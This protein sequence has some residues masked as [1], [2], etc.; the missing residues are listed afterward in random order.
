MFG[1]ED[2]SLS[3]GTKVYGGQHVYV[4][5][6]TGLVKYTVPT[7]GYSPLGSLYDGWSIDNEQG[8]GLASLSWTGGLAFCSATNGK[9][10]SKGPWQLFA[11]VEGKTFGPNCLGVDLLISGNYSEPAAYEYI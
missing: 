10:S 7:S 4:E 9:D 2:G 5:A 3:L 1:L 11:Q 6:V 8:P